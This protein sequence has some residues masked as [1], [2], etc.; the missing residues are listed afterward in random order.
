LRSSNIRCPSNQTNTR[1]KVIVFFGSDGTGKS[2]QAALLIEKLEK[3][4]FKTKR[5]WIRGRH[6]LAFFVSQVLLKL[7]YQSYIAAPDAPA[8]KILDSRKLP[9]KRLWSLIEFLSIAPLVFRRVYIPLTFGSSIV[10]ERF[11]IDSI[12]YNSYFIG[13]EFDP[14]AKILLHMI[15]GNALLIHLDASREDVLSRRSGE[16]FS[17][18]FID[19]QLG[20]YRIFARKL[21]ALSIDSST[22]S[23]EKTSE[24]INSH[25]FLQEHLL[26]LGQETEIDSFLHP[27]RKVSST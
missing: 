10:A 17:V 21:H 22:N 8:G 20:Q 16:I 24:I 7:G 19:F 3:R 9:C 14:Y 15:P 23:I 6:S 18:D 4:G 27:E 12:V 25:V 2:T 13:K 5:V 26:K 11:V 1:P